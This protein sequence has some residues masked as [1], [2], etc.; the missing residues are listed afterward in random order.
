M[1]IF[2]KR[3]L[4]LSG[5]LM[6]GLFAVAQQIPS[7]RVSAEGKDVKVE[8]GQPSKKGRVIFGGLEPYGQ[9]WRAGANEVTEITFAKDAT[10]AGKPVKA[11]KYSL[12]VIPNEKDWTVILNSNVGFWGTKYEENKAKDYLHVTV[13]TKKLSAPEEK[14]TYTFTGSDMNI[15]WDQT[16]VTV[17]IKTS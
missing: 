9:V 8:Y 14:L 6:L 16:Q 17:P 4:F 13:P 15:M 11:G 2:M 1:I 5:I 12:F 7:P 3:A 10:F